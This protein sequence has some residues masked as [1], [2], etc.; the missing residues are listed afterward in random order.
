MPAELPQQSKEEIELLDK[1]F[2]GSNRI[3][4]K[5]NV[6]KYWPDPVQ[7]PKLFEELGFSCIQIDAIAIPVVIDDSR[8]S[9]DA[10][11]AIIQS[12]AEQLLESMDMTIR[13]GA[14]TLQERELAELKACIKERTYKRLR[15]VQKGTRI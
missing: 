1:L 9:L 13:S 7:L 15:L 6:G 8:N 5:H 2:K 10:K 4:E 11:I 3:I 12:E 14:G